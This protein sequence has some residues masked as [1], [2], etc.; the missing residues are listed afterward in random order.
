[1]TPLWCDLGFFRVTNS[2]GESPPYSFQVPRKPLANSNFSSSETE[3][4]GC[5]ND[6][7]DA[8]AGPDH[9][10]HRIVIFMTLA[11]ELHEQV[12]AGF[13]RR[14]SAVIVDMFKR[15]SSEHLC[16]FG[17][18]QGRSISYIP[19][20]NISR[21]LNDLELNVSVNEAEDLFDEFKTNMIVDGLEL[22][23]LQALLQKPSQLHDWARNLALYDLFADTIPRKPGVDPLRVI[24]E[25]TSAEM[26]AICDEMRYGLK[27][28]LKDASELLKKAFVELERRK[29]KGL[30][31]EAYRFNSVTLSYGKIDDFH[32]GIEERIGEI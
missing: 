23:G 32:A 21:L 19:K 5:R 1:M 31:A 30:A 9:S 14:D 15:Y 3:S 13:R 20:Y 16:N 18:Q 7:S 10:T 27:R 11:E 8:N 2:R 6:N 29:E 26:D 24:S 17:A 22:S 12:E 25:L 28:I 4:W